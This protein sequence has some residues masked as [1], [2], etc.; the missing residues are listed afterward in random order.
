MATYE[1]EK[2]T[3]LDGVRWLSA[4]G[5]LGKKSS[6]GNV[7]VKA[8]EKNIVAITPS[9]KSYLQLAASGRLTSADRLF[10]GGRKFATG[11]R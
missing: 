1:K 6:G 5:Y 4:N 10:V 8:R 7:S 11:N 2:Q 3:V 9:G